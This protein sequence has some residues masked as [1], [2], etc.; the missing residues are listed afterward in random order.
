MAVLSFGSTSRANTAIAIKNASTSSLSFGLLRSTIFAPNAVE[1]LTFNTLD[2]RLRFN[3]EA[4]TLYTINAGGKPYLDDVNEFCAL[5]RAGTVQ[6]YLTTQALTSTTYAS[7]AS[8]AFTA[9][10]DGS[11]AFS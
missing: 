6:V 7:G 4:S 1:F 11:V 3:P 5:V 2:Q 10:G 9:T 8:A